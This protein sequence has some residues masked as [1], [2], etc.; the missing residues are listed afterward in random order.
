MG[1]KKTF[2][3]SAAMLVAAALPVQSSS[4]QPTGHA[5]SVLAG[6]RPPAGRY[7]WDAGRRRWVYASHTNARHHAKDAWWNRHREGKHHQKSDRA[8]FRWNKSHH[9]KKHHKHHPKGHAY[10]LFNGR[11]HT[12]N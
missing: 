4:A 9:S 1:K 11:G 8:W 2:V 6:N 7:V 10:G 5:V 3:L 12:K